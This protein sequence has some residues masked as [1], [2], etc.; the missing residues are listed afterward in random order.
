MPD[1]QARAM[2][3]QAR[4]NPCAV[5]DKAKYQQGNLVSLATILRFD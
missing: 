3:R 4:K 2:R 5:M 1:I